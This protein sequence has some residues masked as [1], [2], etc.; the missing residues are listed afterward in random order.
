M[1]QWLLLLI[2]PVASSADA[3]PFNFVS[4]TKYADVEFSYPTDAAA[5]PALVR[6]FKAELAK[7]RSST[8]SC[9][10][11]EFGDPHPDRR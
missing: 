1:K 7:E 5:V 9:G 4:K 3:Q 8:L 11:Q 6:A 2:L 10:K